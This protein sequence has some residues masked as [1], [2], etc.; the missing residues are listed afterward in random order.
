MIAGA[1]S[2]VFRLS[3]GDYVLRVLSVNEEIVVSGEKEI[4]HDFEVEV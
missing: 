3:P 1:D 4:V 2:Q